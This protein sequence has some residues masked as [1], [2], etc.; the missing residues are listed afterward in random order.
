[1]MSKKYWRFEEEESTKSLSRCTQ[2][3]KENREY[4]MI[5]T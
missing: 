2:E 5:A 3:R 4:T 1:M